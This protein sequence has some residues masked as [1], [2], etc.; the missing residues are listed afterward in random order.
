MP[1]WFDRLRALF[2]DTGSPLAAE[3]IEALSKLRMMSA[4]DW[5][6]ECCGKTM[7]GIP[8]IAF[9]SPDCW[10]HDYNYESNA[11]LRYEGD[12]LSSDFCVVDGETFFVRTVMSFS[13]QNLDHELG[14]GV[15]STLSRD[16][17]E[18]YAKDLEDEAAEGGA[19]YFSWLGNAIPHVA[20]DGPLQTYIVTRGGAM[21]AIVV[22]QQD[23][24][25]G[26]GQANGL[27]PSIALDLLRMGEHT[28]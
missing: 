22:A 11:D 28:L 16:N 5:T 1:S 25:A 4:G 24:V 14:I 17:F 8:D 6:C 3:E 27:K 19:E 7:S 26:Y 21:R 12:F 23:T 20:D 15:W 9:N 10:P 2:S 13:I 18:A